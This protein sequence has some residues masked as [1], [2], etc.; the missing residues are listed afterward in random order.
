VRTDRRERA[1]WQA[2]RALLAHPERLAQAFTRR[3]HAD[4][5]GQPQA[6]IALNRQVSKLRQGLA[7]LIDRSAE[8]LMDKQAFEPRVTRLRQRIMHVEAQGHQLAAAETLQRALQ[9]IMGRVEAC[10]AQVQQNLD[11]LEWHRQREILRPLVQRVE[12]G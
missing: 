1:V 9:L 3:L 10:A 7:R 2:V 8:G 6:R 11:A 12:I 5:Q 4:G